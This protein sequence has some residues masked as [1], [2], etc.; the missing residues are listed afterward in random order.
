MLS[1]SLH[2][3]RLHMHF[4]QLC[5][6]GY[7]VWIDSNE[8]GHKIQVSMNEGVEKSSVRLCYTITIQ[9]NTNTIQSNVKLYFK[10]ITDLKEIT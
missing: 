6:L 8:M 2:A 1:L 7:K 9:C 4:R 10:Y 3:L 5:N